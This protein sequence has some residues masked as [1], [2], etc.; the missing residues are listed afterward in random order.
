MQD[1]PSVAMA[2]SKFPSLPTLIGQ[3]TDELIDRIPTFA[4]FT[5]DESI[6]GFS[7]AFLSYVDPAVLA[8]EVGMYKSADYKDIGP[9]GSGTQW[10]RVVDIDN[11][12]Q[13]FCPVYQ[14]AL[15]ISEKATVWK[16]KSPRVE[17]FFLI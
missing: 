4:N 14:A 7:Q 10:S 15:R 17:I 16:C 3:T 1:Y 12:L 9:P 8:E 5:T 13:A 2:Q 6:L 11:D